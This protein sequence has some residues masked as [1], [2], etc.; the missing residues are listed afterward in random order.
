[1]KEKD[2]HLFFRKGFGAIVGPLYI[3]EIAPLHVRGS[4][5]AC[6]QLFVAMAILLAQLLGLDIYLGQKHLWNYLFGLL[7]FLIC[8]FFFDYF[9]SIDSGA[10]CFQSTSMCFVVIYI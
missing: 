10:H 5:G 1:M 6:F 8:F 4:F 3:T 7:N 2:V 9:S